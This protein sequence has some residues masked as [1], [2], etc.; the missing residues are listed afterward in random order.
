[1]FII[2]KV[3]KNILW[4]NY[5]LYFYKEKKPDFQRIKLAKNTKKGNHIKFTRL[6][7]WGE[8][9]FMLDVLKL[10]FTICH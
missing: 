2:C 10:I 8:L 9:A 6:F 7:F 4:C 3:T 1:M 5:F